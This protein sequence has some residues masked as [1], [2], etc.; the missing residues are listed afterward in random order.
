VQ[1]ADHENN[2]IKF[3]NDVLSGGGGLNNFVTTLLIN[4]QNKLVSQGFDKITDFNVAK[5]T[6]T[7]VGVNDM[8]TLNSHTT[9]THINDGTIINFDGGGSITLDHVNVNSLSSLHVTP[10]PTLV[11][12]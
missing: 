4:D 7:F 8:A 5:D 1:V 3:G 11:I 12:V 10:T 6:L 2:T 9:L